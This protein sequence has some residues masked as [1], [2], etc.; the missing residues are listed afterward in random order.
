[1]QTGSSG[2]AFSFVAEKVLQNVLYVNSAN[3]ERKTSGKA[4]HVFI[5]HKKSALPNVGLFQLV[6]YKYSNKKK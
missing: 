5:R 2:Q 4:R 1:M 3:E 6:Y